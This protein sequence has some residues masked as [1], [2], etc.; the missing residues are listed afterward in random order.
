MRLY[1]LIDSFTLL[2]PT[3]IDRAPSRCWNVSHGERI[4]ISE[5]EKNFKNDSEQCE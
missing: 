3:K 2:N 1:N 5:V 4:R